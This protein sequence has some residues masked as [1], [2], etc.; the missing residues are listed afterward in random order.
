MSCLTRHV[1]L[2]THAAVAIE[3]WLVHTFCFKCFAHTPR[4]HAQSPT[5]RCGKTVLLSLLSQLANRALFSTD[6]SAAVLFR[7]MEKV[8][9]TIIFDEWD[10]A[11]H[12]EKG[13]ALRNVLNSGFQQ[14]GVTWR[15]VRV[16][17]RDFDARPFPTFGPVVV[18]GIGDLPDT[19]ADR[20]ITI[21]MR[22]KIPG[23]KTESIRGFDGSDL[24]R[25]CQRWVQDNTDALAAARPEIPAQL[26]DRQADCWE[27]LLAIA[28]VA[29][30]D[31]ARLAREAAVA[32]SA[33]DAAKD[34]GYGAALLADIRKFFDTHEG[35]RAFCGDVYQFLIGLPDSPWGTLYKGQPITRHKLGRMLSA[36]G[37]VSGTIRDDDRADK[38]WH[39]EQ[40]VE[41]WRR[42]LPPDDGD[43]AAAPVANG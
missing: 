23:E 16:E 24:K 25:Q 10:S 30:G 22:R 8:Q 11:A 38:G 36:F 4:L 37:I 39:R 9:P 34:D 19:V 29:G 31:W 33:A 20:S 15:A 41:V 1:V 35:D 17:G 3:L 5:K 21:K 12:G 13:E 26:N 43:A 2:P 28:D 7:V 6:L 27:P 32:L 14:N 40:F 42:Y 18:A